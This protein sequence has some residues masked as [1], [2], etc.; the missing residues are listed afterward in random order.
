VASDFPDLS[1]QGP[2]PTPE[3]LAQR[4]AFRLVM[5]SEGQTLLAEL[6]A[7]PIAE[8]DEV[9]VLTK[10]RASY[11]PALVNAVFAQVKLRLRARAK[12]SRADQM[13]FTADGLEQ[14]STE[15]MAMYHGT[16]LHAFGDIFDL[17]SG[18][19]GDLIG[20]A[21]RHAV[22]AVDIDP[23]HS[24]MGVLN[25]GAYGVA[26][27]VQPLVGDVEMLDLYP[28]AELPTRVAFFVDPARRAGGRRMSGGESQ[29]SLEW[30][31]SL[32]QNDAAVAV[33]AWPAIPLDRPPT[34]WGIEFVSEGR[35]LKEALL[36]SPALNRPARRATV[37][38]PD[39][40][41]LDAAPGDDI[42]VRAPGEYLLD[43]DAAVTRAG[44]VEDLA[45]ALDGDVWKIDNEV[46]FLSSR[47]PLRTPFGRTLKI[48]ASLPW[49][50]NR[51]KEA[52]RSLD[53]GSVDI[54]KRG[55]AV[56]VDDIQRR[57]K[58]TGTL[59]ATVVLTRVVDKPWAFVCTSDVG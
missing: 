6:S 9:R 51:L 28:G 23:V 14:A 34:D 24:H 30:C 46:A 39:V 32:A 59:P 29:P 18:I 11:A 12:F 49:N 41:S 8:S 10:Y 50:L 4:E 35:E 55:S 56:D 13:Y 53:I 1:E 2:P 54:R 3:A 21:Q 47:E 17:C 25:A 45:R 57:L 52:L 20:L 19:G 48:A 37:L 27:R 33:K 26:N 44:L 22:M 16:V 36:V 43:P 7:R 42:A 58:L 38:L 5:S 15:R 40:R 31:F